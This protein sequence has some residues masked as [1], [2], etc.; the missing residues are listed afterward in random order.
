MEIV[1]V[2][3][4]DGVRECRECSECRAC[5]KPNSEID[6]KNAEQVREPASSGALGQSALEEN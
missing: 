2:A 5:R 3:T 4:P 6:K 1:K